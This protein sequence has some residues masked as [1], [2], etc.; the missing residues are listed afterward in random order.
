MNGV[1]YILDNWLPPHLK[2]SHYTQQNILQ[3]VDDIKDKDEV[4]EKSG[5]YKLL[6]KML[7]YFA[8][9]IRGEQIIRALKSRAKEHERCFRL[10][11]KSSNFKKHILESCHDSVIISRLLNPVDIRLKIN[12]SEIIDIVILGKLKN[13]QLCDNFLFS[14]SSPLRA[15]PCTSTMVT[16]PHR[17]QPKH[18][19]TIST[20]PM[21]PS[22]PPFLHQCPVKCDIQ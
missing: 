18:S 21:T 16:T 5:L 17:H 20:F 9:Y 7:G 3:L 14:P 19:L 4:L 13:V 6:N 15:T 8:L 11:Y 2:I 10:G 1:T 12:S 22:P